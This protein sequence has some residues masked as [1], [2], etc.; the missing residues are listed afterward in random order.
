MN[1]HELE[2]QPPD[3]AIHAD[4][5]VLPL[6]QLN[7]SL[8]P[9]VGGKAAQL[10]ELIH[11][12]FAV[13]TGFCV[14]TTAYARV[15]ASAGLDALLAEL[16]TVPAAETARLAELATAVCAAILHAPVVSDIA[17]AIV[18]AYQALNQDGPVPVAV[19][20][21]ATAEDLPDASFAGQQETFLNVV[22]AEAVLDAVRR[23]WASL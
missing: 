23:C 14:T 21:S 17:S 11:A 12:G 22:G 10:G 15:S 20:S 16:S 13:P 8:L 4:A 1:R 3:Q 7:R 18:K 2:F 9:L 5:L 19:R 6:D